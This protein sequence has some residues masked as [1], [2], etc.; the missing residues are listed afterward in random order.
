MNHLLVA[1]VFDI[2][3]FLSQNRN[4]PK[5]RVK[6]KVKLFIKMTCHGGKNCFCFLF[7]FCFFFVQ[8]N[9]P[10]K[11]YFNLMFLSHMGIYQILNSC[12]VQ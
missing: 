8:K 12:L 2:S 4:T 6:K 5:H 1:S 9:L 11:K 7:V 10:L 3:L